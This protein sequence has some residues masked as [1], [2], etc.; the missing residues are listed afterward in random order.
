MS[1]MTRYYSLV[2]CLNSAADNMAALGEYAGSYEE[3]AEWL[4]ESDYEAL[5]N[6]LV[7][8]GEFTSEDEAE[9]Y[10]SDA[11]DLIIKSL[12]SLDN[13]TA[14][15]IRGGNGEL[16]GYQLT[17]E[18]VSCSPIHRILCDMRLSTDPDMPTLY[19]PAAYL[20]D[21]VYY[22]KQLLP[23]SKMVEIAV[24]KE[25]W[26]ITV[27]TDIPDGELRQFY[28]IAN[29]FGSNTDISDIIAEADR[30][31]EEGDFLTDIDSA[32]IT[33]AEAVCDGSEQH[34]AVTVTVGGTVLTEGTDFRVVY[35]GSIE[36][37]EAQ[38]MVI[39]TGKYT[40]T[41]TA[42]YTIEKAEE[43]SS[44]SGS[45][46]E[47][48][49]EPEDDS[50]FESEPTDDSTE[51]SD[52][53]TDSALDPTSETDSSAPKKTDNTSNPATGSVSFIGIA[54]LAAAGLVTLRKRK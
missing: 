3:L 18:G 49:S 10:L 42:A 20:T 27:S 48:S 45:E 54:V 51:T 30:A 1:I 34:P 36:A 31:A 25:N 50:S 52:R 17:S 16:L 37:G 43:T 8:L 32:G 9:K 19:S 46:D 7:S 33:V 29:I 23:S 13:I 4:E 28:R 5:V 26:G 2:Q 14:R 24:D 11:A 21:A 6:C 44:E 41:K 39:G 40:G 38:L 35:D 22:R 47:S 53:E 15:Q 12:L